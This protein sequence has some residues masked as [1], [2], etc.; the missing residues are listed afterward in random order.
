[1]KKKEMKVIIREDTKK[2]WDA[3]QTNKGRYG[4]NHITTD[5]ALSRWAI[6]DD[7]CKKLEISYE[8]E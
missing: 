1:M 4:N 7:L 6:L 2:A 5:Y 3:L 8:K